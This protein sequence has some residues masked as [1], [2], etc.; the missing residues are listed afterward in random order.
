LGTKSSATGPVAACGAWTAADPLLD[1]F[2]KDT[3]DGVGMNPYGSPPISN[4]AISPDVLGAELTV[5]ATPAVVLVEPDTALIL[6]GYVPDAT[7]EAFNV[8][9]LDPDPPSVAGLKAMVIPDGK[10]DA[11]NV[12]VPLNEPSAFT[13]AVPVAFPP[14]SMLTLPLETES[15]KLPEPDFEPDPPPQAERV[16][17]AAPKAIQQSPERPLVFPFMS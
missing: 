13:V 8:K 10:P 5:T 2:T 14:F 7:L 11:D 17:N 9:V 4:A 15:V 6:T 3:P 16:S 12:M 1:S